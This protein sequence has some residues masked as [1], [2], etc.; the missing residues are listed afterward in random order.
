MSGARAALIVATTTH[1]DPALGRLAAPSGDAQHL[2]RILGEPTVGGFTVETMLNAS[3]STIQERVEAFFQ[4][5]RTTTDFLLLYFSGHGVKD[6]DGRL[7]FA[8][9][10]TRRERLRSTA[11]P[12]T[13]VHDVML[14]S[15]PRQQVLILDCCYSGAFAR[16]L[17][18]KGGGRAGVGEALGGTHDLRGGRG[19]IVLTA[20]DAIQYSFE[21]AEVRGTGTQSVFTSVLI[22]GMESGDADLDG[23]GWISID[24][25]YDY[26]HDRVVARTP[27]QRPGKWGFGLEGAMFV[28][29]NPAA[30]DRD[31]TPAATAR[32]ATAGPQE[33]TGLAGRARRVPRRALL[34][35][36]LLVLAAVIAFV[37]RAVATSEDKS[38]NTTPNRTPTAAVYRQVADDTNMLRVRVPASWG[39]VWGDGWHPTGYPPYEGR[40]GPGLNAS[41]NNETWFKDLTTPGVFLG[42]SSLLPKSYTPTTAVRRVSIGSCR[43]SDGGSYRDARYDG[44]FLQLTCP[45]SK[46]TWYV[47]AAW[48]VDHSYLVSVQVKLVD[49]ADR[50]A[51][52]E[53]L[54]SFEVTGTP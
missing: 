23:D 17:V 35:G 46:T 10:N 50:A 28:A 54:A 18:A 53:V 13:F 36:S 15:R 34:A 49:E 1:D 51:L 22:E 9:S 20:S 4:E 16:G 37:V 41:P 47:M 8:A 26:A 31:G 3:S 11:V 43:T 21:G 52:K 40:I 42:A 33:P 27:A 45:G 48:P 12:A 29:R 14:A 7:Y 6:E 24:E 5:N 39:N 44:E 38:A 2:A 32:V 30:F 25:L 19:R